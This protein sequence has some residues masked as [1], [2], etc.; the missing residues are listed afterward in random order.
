MEELTLWRLQKD[1]WLPVTREMKG[2]LTEDFQ[3]G[4]T[5]VYAT[6]VDVCH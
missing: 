6:V 5:G 4:E 1:P 3:G 2:S